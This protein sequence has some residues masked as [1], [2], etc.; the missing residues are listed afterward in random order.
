MIQLEDVYNTQSKDFKKMM[1]IIDKCKSEPVLD[2][3]AEKHHIIPK[4]YYKRNK[5]KIDNSKDNL[6]LLPE[7]E[8]ILVHYYS[9]GCIKKEY[10]TAMIMATSRL[11]NIP[12][13]LS[14]KLLE[15]NKE[16]ILSIRKQKISANGKRVYC[17]ETKTVYPSV[18]DAVRKFQTKHIADIC[19]GKYVQG[20]GY[21]FCWEKDK[22]NFVPKKKISSLKG[23]TNGRGKKVICIESGE[24]FES[25]RDVCWRFGWDVNYNSCIH[26]NC[27]GKMKQCKGYHFRW[28]E[29]EVNASR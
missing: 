20:H 24:I 2:M 28:L 10:K 13:K 4:C 26:Q 8:H 22:D 17:Y 11:I 16:I 14:L 1:A 21:H 29:E 27:S 15:E 7:W 12:G 3:R 19:N 5:L 9:I 23:K 6:I 25:T 18:R